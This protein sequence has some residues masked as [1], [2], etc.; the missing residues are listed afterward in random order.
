[1]HEKYSAAS[2]VLT[3]V[4]Y[5][6]AFGLPAEGKSANE[7]SAQYG[8][9]TELISPAGHPFF[10]Y[11][12]RGATSDDTQLSVAV[13]E[14]LIAASGF[15][16]DSQAEKHITAYLETPV[17]RDTEGALLARGWGKSTIRA[18]ERLIEGVSPEY[19]GEKQGGGNGVVMKMA[20]LAIWQAFQGFDIATRHEQYD[21][22]T[23][24]THDSDIARF[25]T[26]LH[27]DVIALL[28]NGNG[29]LDDVIHDAV[30][31]LPSDMYA[32][33][34]HMLKRATVD[35]CDTFEALVE[36]YAVGNSG[37]KYGFYVP[38]TLAMTYDILLGS[39]GDFETAVQWA[40][41]LGGD[42]DSTASIVA[43]LIAC[44]T[45][46]AF[47][48]PKDFTDVQDYDQL[49]RTS[50]VFEKLVETSFE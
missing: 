34:A 20:P 16:I 25:C 11:E 46:G 26:R 21:S 33:E 4:A 10:P 17:I 19:S 43:S 28:L 32:R 5:G 18:M 15:S 30:Q 49:V 1:M 35:P 22:L 48:K 47:Q 39:G 12:S 31:T 50:E 44:S 45:D 13:A 40:A 3:A 6:D 38:E 2:T 14:G 7:I 42:A 23:T 24:M 29:Y 27:G 9:I 41:N 36:R 37:K 8:T